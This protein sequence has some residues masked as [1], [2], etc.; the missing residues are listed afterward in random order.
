MTPSV[1]LWS[2]IQPSY[3]TVLITTDAL[4]WLTNLPHI[5][6]PY[7]QFRHPISSLNNRHILCFPCRDRRAP[8]T[9]ASHPEFRR[10]P[11]GKVPCP[12]L[13]HHRARWSHGLGGIWRVRTLVLFTDIGTLFSYIN[14]HLIL[15]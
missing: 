15:T 12:R 3:Q 5:L 1:V 13:T 2:V 9:T 7:P 6:K 14:F 10:R 11:H 8:V 4:A